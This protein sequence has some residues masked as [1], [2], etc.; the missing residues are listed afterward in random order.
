MRET[1]NNHNAIHEI[2]IYYKQLL[3]LA[4]ML[5]A[6]IFHA[7]NRMR[8]RESKVGQIFS[9]W[10][11]KEKW[12]RL[13]RKNAIKGLL[14]HGVASLNEIFETK[15]PHGFC[16]LP[17]IFQLR[18]KRKDNDVCCYRSWYLSKANRKLHNKIED[19]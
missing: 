12:N 10:N 11:G 14:T 3:V 16:Y 8:C 7:Y 9:A 4:S 17:D 18:N 5:Y 13:F 6:L 19:L 2:L 15:N 1:Y